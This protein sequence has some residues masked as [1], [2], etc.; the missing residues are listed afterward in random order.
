M[1]RSKGLEFPIVYCPFLWEPG[2]IPREAR[3]AFF[4]DPDADDARTIDVA[5]EGPD[6]TRHQQQSLVERRGE[7]LRLAY[8]ALTR[9][10]HQA[11]IWWA[12]SWGCRDSPLGRLLFARDE[13]GSSAERRLDRRRRRGASSRFEAA[14]P[15]R[16]AAARSR[17]RRS[18][19]RAAGGWARRAAAA[20]AWLGVRVR[21]RP[22][23]A[24]AA[25]VLQ[26]HHRRQSRGLGDRASQRRPT[27]WPDG[28]R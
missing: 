15:R 12:G 6:F 28:R 22:R 14:R 10:R 27:W 23:P 7:D 18:A 20:A 9:A 26:R 21:P 19:A 16:T 5:L 1:H 24:L 11:V 8:V 13:Y 17:S 2:Y 25:H 3:P 4:H